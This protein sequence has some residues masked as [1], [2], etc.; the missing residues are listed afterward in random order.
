MVVIPA[1]RYRM[2][3][4][5]GHEDCD[6]FGSEEPVHEVSIAAAFEVSRHEITYAQWDACV[7]LGGCDGHEP[8]D[9][10]QGRGNRPV[11]D[12]NWGQA[13][14]YV[15]SL[16]L[17]T[18][19]EYRLLTEAEWEYAA[20]A[21]AST[22]F[23]W[24]DEVG[25]DRANCAQDICADEYRFTA[26]WVPSRRMPGACSTCMATSANGWRTAGTTTTKARRTPRRPGR[27]ACA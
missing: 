12:V 18:G 4:L 25:H 6:V 3:C 10:G 11:T 20:R 7:A 13:K 8:S 27:T 1:G 14:A 21:G 2:G 23:S 26:P 22:K 9:F 5:A 24:G 19:K 17:A 15:A 16:S